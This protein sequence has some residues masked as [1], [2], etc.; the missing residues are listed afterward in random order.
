MIITLESYLAGLRDKER[1]KPEGQRLE[2]PT[3]TDLAIAAGVD[4]ATISRLA[5]GKIR[6]LSFNVGTSILD[7]LH[8][9][10]FNPQVSDILVYNPPRPKDSI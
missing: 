4:G 10:G 8:R 2:V 7:E 6:A 9:R 5:R 1:A 3:Y